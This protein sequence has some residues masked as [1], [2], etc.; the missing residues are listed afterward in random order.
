[1]DVHEEL[2]IAPATYA[3]LVDALEEAGLFFDVSTAKGIYVERMNT[4]IEDMYKKYAV[5]PIQV[6][7]LSEVEGGVVKVTVFDAEPARLD[8]FQTLF[9]QNWSTDEIAMVRSGDFFIDFMR[10]HV[11][12]GTALAR[13]ASSKGIASEHV[14][15][16]GNY[17][18]DIEM[19]SFAGMGIAV[20]NATEDVK[21]VADVMVASNNEDGVAEAIAL[22]L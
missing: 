18:N 7:S 21:Q 11:N 14:V 17:N 4:A 9:E 15:A 1:M 3:K 10:P 6:A 20:A 12:K 16:V 13:Y 8:Q 2:A 22:I 19:L 5:V